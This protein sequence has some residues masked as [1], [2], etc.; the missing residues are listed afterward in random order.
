MK[1]IKTRSIELLESMF[2]VG[3]FVVDENDIYKELSFDEIYNKCTNSIRSWVEE[4]EDLKE[5]PLECLIWLNEH[6]EEIAKLSR[7]CSM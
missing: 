1:D 7:E 2:D 5:M 4:G 3:Y 6:P